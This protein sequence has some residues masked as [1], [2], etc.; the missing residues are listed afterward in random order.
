MN[1]NIYGINRLDSV[2][3]YLCEMR[4]NKEL[5]NLIKSGNIHKK[6][7]LNLNDKIREGMSIMEIINIIED[8]IML[9][10]YNEINKG[11]AFPV[12]VSIN[13][14]CAHYTLHKGDERKLKKGDVLKIDYGVHKDGYITDSAFTISL[15]K[16]YDE[17]MRI[18][19]NATMY[20]INN[21]NI[22]MDIGDWGDLIQEYVS[23]KEVE[24]DNKIYGLKTIKDL[25]G[26]SIKRYNVHGG[27]FLPSFR[28]PGYNKK[29]DNGVWA[30]ELFITNGSGEVYY[31]DNDTSHYRMK[32]MNINI[33][34][35]R[36]FKGICNKRFNGLP[37]CDRWVS[38]LE[39][40][41]SNLN[42]LGNKKVVDKYPPVYDKI[43]ES[44]VCQY[45]HS[46]YLKDEEKINLTEGL[47][48]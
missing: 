48:Y 35:L 43:K 46:I 25:T 8:N 3:N 18:S 32:D 36:K 2:N 24:I 38:D 47:D 45:E 9:N 29:I 12:G 39:N 44:I 21:L 42:I 31:D 11:R 33:E 41:K 15:D 1:Y 5:S 27:D 17:I 40:Y 28:F 16:K 22:G 10:S 30:V 7:R 4:D 19:R 13:N 6:V 34:R 20:G 26:H 23:S 14:C 37:F